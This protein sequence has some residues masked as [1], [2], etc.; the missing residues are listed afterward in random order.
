MLV[1]DAFCGH[2]SEELKV[3][4]ERKNFD[5]V[6]IPGGMTSQLQPLDVSVN[7][8]FKYYSRKEY[9][10]WLMCEN[11]PPTSSGNVKRASASELA[12]WVSVTGKKIA[13]KTGEQ[14]SKKCCIT[15]MLI[16]TEDNI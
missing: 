8:P 12:G 3:K 16:D 1:L 15:D 9:E 2:L 10:V 5:L 7:K 14:S 13:K 11:V 6:V 4:L